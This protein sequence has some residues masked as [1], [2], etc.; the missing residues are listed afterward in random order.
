MEYDLPGVSESVFQQRVVDLRYCGNISVT[1]LNKDIEWRFGRK[2]AIAFSLSDKDLESIVAE[3]FG[4]VVRFK[5][6][7]TFG[8][9]VRINEAKRAAIMIDVL[10]RHQDRGFFKIPDDIKS[11][12]YGELIPSMFIYLVACSTAY[13]ARLAIDADLERDMLYCI[14]HRK[15]IDEEWLCWSMAVLQRCAL[16]KEK[17]VDRDKD[18]ARMRALRARRLKAGGCWGWL[19]SCLGR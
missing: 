12:A 6:R 8:D 13:I 9:G 15:N 2:D 5:E 4:R 19:K 14:Y 3:Y 1:T 16:L 10:L 11:M 18:L 17:I 7:N